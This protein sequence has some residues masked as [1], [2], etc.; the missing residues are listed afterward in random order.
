MI[1][2]GILI[3]APSSRWAIRGRITTQTDNQGI[4]VFTGVIGPQ[5]I[6][7]YACAEDAAPTP[8]IR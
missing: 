5:D 8:T 6:H 1:S 3:R 4:A 2:P 7:V